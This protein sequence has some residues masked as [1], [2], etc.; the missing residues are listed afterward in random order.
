MSG[1]SE[2]EVR[3]KE[4]AAGGRRAWWPFLALFRPAVTQRD[5]HAV[6][7]SAGGY[8]ALS[9]DN[10]QVRAGLGRCGGWDGHGDRGT[11]AHVPRSRGTR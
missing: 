3:G 8:G 2:P 11:A 1:L 4:P 6:R 9:Y 7:H 5:E 10:L